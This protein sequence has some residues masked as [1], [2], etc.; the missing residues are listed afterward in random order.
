MSACRAAGSSSFSA[1][2]S[3]NVIAFRRSV[4]FALGELPGRI[5]DVVAD[6]V[7][8]IARDLGHSAAIEFVDVRV[9]QQLDLL[10]SD[11][12]DEVRRGYP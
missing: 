3:W 8:D 9:V 10:L 6:A 2:A 5:R 7:K 11:P 4:V 1:S 12:P